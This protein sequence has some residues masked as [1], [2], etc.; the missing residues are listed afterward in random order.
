MLQKIEDKTYE[1][2]GSVLSVKIFEIQLAVACLDKLFKVKHI[3]KIICV[4]YHI[5]STI[6]KIRMTFGRRPL[7]VS[8]VAYFILINVTLLCSLDDTKDC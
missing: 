8:E 3:Y 1:D 5:P 6:K 7:K 4:W 2:S